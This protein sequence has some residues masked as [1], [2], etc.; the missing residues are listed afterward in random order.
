MAN[1][2]EI[3]VVGTPLA[4]KT[5]IM[6][7]VRRIF[8]GECAV[9]D[10]AITEKGF[11]HNR[12]LRVANLCMNYG[13][14]GGTTLS[15]KWTPGAA[16]QPEGAYT[17]LREP[18]KKVIL[19]VDVQSGLLDRQR[20][21]WEAIRDMVPE[22]RCYFILNKNDMSE[23]S[24]EQIVAQVGLPCERPSIRIS[25]ANSLDPTSLIREFFVSHILPQEK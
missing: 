3:A 8:G 25:A 19:V 5:T 24:T 16:P 10:V 7:V 23:C 22:E 14:G 12:A 6:E 21:Y 13:A 4:G 20:E 1:T 18:G 17:L 2:S 9:S 15:F 11:W